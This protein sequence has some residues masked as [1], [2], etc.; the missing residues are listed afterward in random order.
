MTCPFTEKDTRK[1]IMSSDVL[2]SDA[3]TTPP[4]VSVPN[5]FFS[6]SSE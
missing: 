6:V 2:F 5:V 4:S 1:A 3:Y